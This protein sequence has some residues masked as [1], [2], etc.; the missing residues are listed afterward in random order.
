[1]TAFPIAADDPAPD[2][3]GA[4]GLQLRALA[5]GRAI[6]GEALFRSAVTAAGRRRPATPPLP[7]EAADPAVAAVL[8]TF[9]AFRGGAFTEPR[10]RRAWQPTDLSYAFGVEAA[11]TDG[12][13]VVL[14][15]DAFPGGHLDW[16][17][18]DRTDGAA[19]SAAADPVYTTTNMLPGHVTFHGMPS[20]RW[21]GFEDGQT[22]F[23]Q[24]D[25]QHVD[26]AK[27]LVM[28]FALVYG[29]DWFLPPGAKRRRL[30]CRTSRRWS[31]P[32][33]SASGR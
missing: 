7:S 6:D 12:E 25:A 31:S 13:S 5:A 20:D 29:S 15:A 14:E 32:T 30:E 3:A 16:Y 17:S 2:L 33:P 10:R 18:F 24:L 21:W 8:D 4:A 11:S 22:D 23:G 28:E 27:L 26:L 19:T 9:A 1:M